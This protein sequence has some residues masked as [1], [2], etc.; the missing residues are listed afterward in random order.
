MVGHGARHHED[1]GVP[2]CGSDK[3]SQTVHVVI[4][5]V[6]LLDFAQAGA[7]GPGIKDPEV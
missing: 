7:A 3:E 5:L 4:R 6:E 1:I 2:G